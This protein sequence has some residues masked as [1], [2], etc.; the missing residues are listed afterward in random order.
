MHDREARHDKQ[1]KKEKDEKTIVKNKYI[2][3]RIEEFV[4]VAQGIDL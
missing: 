3:Y 2:H 4:L 1:D